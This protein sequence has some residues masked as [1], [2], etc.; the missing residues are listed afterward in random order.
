MLRQIVR[1]GHRLSAQLLLIYKTHVTFRFA[2]DQRRES[3]MEWS[4]IQALQNQAQ[5]KASDAVV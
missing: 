2:E 1:K 5:C 3:F 4:V